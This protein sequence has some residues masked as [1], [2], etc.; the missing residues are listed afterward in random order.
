MENENRQNLNSEIL[1]DSE[2]AQ[3]RYLPRDKPTSSGELPGLEYWRDAAAEAE[4]A[5][6]IPGYDGG[7]DE[8]VFEGGLPGYDGGMESEIFEGGLP[9]YDQD[10]QRTRPRFRPSSRMRR[11]YGRKLKMRTWR[12][13]KTRKPK[14]RTRKSKIGPPKRTPQG[15]AEKIQRAQRQARGRPKGK[16]WRAMRSARKQTA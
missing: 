10:A 15:V 7:M 1:Q 12:A 9:G 6:P 14:T 16:R 4:A 13:S 2:T 11:P 3:V 8:Q 5:R